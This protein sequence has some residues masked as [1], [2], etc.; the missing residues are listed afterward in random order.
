[1]KAPTIQ[2][3]FLFALLA[4]LAATGAMEIAAAENAPGDRATRPNIIFLLTD[5]QRDNTFGAMGHPF[6][7]TPNVDRLLGQAVRFSNTYIAEPVCAPSRVSLLTGMHERV[8]GIGFTSSYRLTDAQWERSYPALLQKAGYH[9]G[10]IGKY[11]V[12]FANKPEKEMFDSFQPLNRNLFWKNH[13]DGTF[14]DVAAETTLAGTKQGSAY[15]HSISSAWGD[16]N[17]DGY[18]D[19]FVANLA[20]PRFLEF[21]DKARLYMSAGGEDPVFEDVTEAEGFRFQETAGGAIAW[22]YD[23][24]GDQDLMWN[25]IYAERPSQFYRNDWPDGGWVEVTY[26]TGLRVTNGWEISIADLDDDGDLDYAANKY[27]GIE[28]DNLFLNKNP[29]D[30]RSIQVRPLGR[31]AGGTNRDGF[32][33]RVRVMVDGVERMQE[34]FP[35]S[36]VSNQSSP[37]LHF[38]IGDADTADVTVEFPITGESYSF[39]SLAAGRYTVDEDGNL[40]QE[41]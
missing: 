5:D 29:W 25:C 39:V 1:M 6:V 21:S 17:H 37:W 11:G 40:T 24:D 19:V 9:T 23:N 38:G 16:F 27:W 10:F 2:L 35:S 14:S 33:A 36:G 13:G 41:R 32:G 34:K 20:H 3:P 26:P 12:S 15:G 31:G 7:K 22:D 30:R 4:A 28:D 18:L 8:H